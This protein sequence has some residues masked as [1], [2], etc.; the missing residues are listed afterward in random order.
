MKRKWIGI[1]IGL[2]LFIS[3]NG[4]LSPRDGPILEN[5][6]GASSVE[7]K[8]AVTIQTTGIK[9]I[10]ETAL[11]I[12]D[13]TDDPSIK[14]SAGIIIEKATALSGV[15][16]V[17]QRNVKAQTE[18]ESLVK[19]Y[20]EYKEKTTSGER[21]LLFMLRIA[22][23]LFVPAAGILFFML[24]SPQML[25]IALGC[26]A[27]LL[28]TRLDAFIVKWGELAIGLFLLGIVA[29]IGYILF[30]HRRS[31]LSAIRVSEA[32]KETVAKSNKK[33][34]LKVLFGEGTVPGTVSHD[35]TTEKQITAARKTVAKKSKSI[36]S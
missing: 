19:Q 9:T 24:K 27:L 8:E 36:K 1:V 28:A 7:I 14:D 3:V 21:R 5:Y 20:A 29:L 18:Y 10:T 30:I 22:A 4:C 17:L 12:R 11:N 16:P 35:A 6:T 32:L 26:P 25:Y 34:E 33:S 2:V 23:I 15:T 13:R 31:L